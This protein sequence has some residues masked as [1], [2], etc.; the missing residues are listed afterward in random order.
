M[1]RYIIAL[2]QGTTSSRAVVFGENHRVVAIAQKETTQYFPQDGWVE[3]DA[4]EIWSS[5]YGVLQE[6]IAKARISAKDI[7]AIGITNQRETT[8]LWDKDTGEAVAP[9]IVWQCRRTMDRCENL[10]KE[11]KAEAIREKTGLFLDAYFSATKI[12]W[13][14]DAVDP[15]RKKAK[16]GKLL[17]G[18]VDSW[19]LYKLTDGKVHA[20]DYTNASRTMLFNIHT[21]SW[22]ADLLAWLDIPKAMLPEVKPSGAF[23]GLASQLHDV[24]IT[25]L[26]GDQ[27]SALYG[28][29]CHKEGMA[30]C[31]YGTGCFLLM[32]TGKTP[33]FSQYGL[34]TTVAAGHDKK[35]SY[36]LEGSVFIGGAV[37]QWLRDGLQILKTAADSDAF[38]KKL[39]SNEGVYLVPAFV[40]LG[41]PHWQMHVRGAMYGLTR[42]TTREH[43]IRAALEAIAYQVQ[44]IT[45]AMEQDTGLVIPALRAG[46]GACNNDFLMQFQADILNKPV[47]RPE[48]TEITAYGAAALAAETVGLW[49]KGSESVE[50]KPFKTYTS[51]MDEKERTKNIAG[52]KKALAKTM[53]E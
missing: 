4:H 17:F 9:A 26:V 2:D 16:E 31:T 8:I 28:H 12:A 23:Y 46:G 18:T 14:L 41:A 35:P 25:A 52:W 6:A 19:L 44:D 40:G 34:V 1:G 32:H 47:I 29:G 45:G 11:N 39:S 24:P 51:M 10:R 15:E 13:I 38:A 20:T 22:D 49:S 27:Q 7:V 42:A 53:L 36:A 50:E 5:T 43:F 3:Q 21:A 37:I 48:E 30:K 33:L